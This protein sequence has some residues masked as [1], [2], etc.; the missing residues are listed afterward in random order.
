MARL[1]LLS[2]GFTGRSYQLKVEKTTVGRVSDNA[3]EIPEASVSSHHAEILLRGNDVVV[4]DLNSTNGTFINSQQITGEAVLKP[5]QILRLGTVEMRL[6]TGEAP[7][8]M[9]A[10]KKKQ[11]QALDQTRVIPQGVKPDE[12]QGSGAAPQFQ[13]TGFEKK[14]NKGAR[15]FAIVAII[16]GIAL[17][18]ALFYVLLK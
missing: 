17:V 5:G 3:F 2:E 6:E 14:S 12:L 4:R 9:A 15:I 7:T 8:A 13:T 10:E 1:V 16:V 18:A 11:A